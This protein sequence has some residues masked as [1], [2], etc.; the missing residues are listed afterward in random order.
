MN[1]IDSLGIY[2]NGEYAGV[3]NE[4]AFD[5][6]ET[7]VAE[8]VKANAGQKNAMS[9]ALGVFGWKDILPGVVPRTKTSSKPFVIQLINTFSSNDRGT[10]IEIPINYE[11]TFES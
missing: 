3:D 6:I 2:I 7:A 1:K 8:G 10:I 9:I 4:N 5:L 11:Q